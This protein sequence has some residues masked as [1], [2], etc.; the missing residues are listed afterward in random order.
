M[1]P[2]DHAQP[3][4][5][6]GRTPATPPDAPPVRLRGGIGRRIGAGFAV[7]IALMLGVT[8]I[9]LGAGRLVEGRLAR[10]VAHSWPQAVQAEAMRE[11][12]NQTSRSVNRLIFL[13][14]VDD[15]TREKARI[16]AAR[17]ASQAALKSLQASVTEPAG[18]ALLREVDAAL[19]AYAP[20]VDA[21]VALIDDNQTEQ[22]RDLALPQLAPL[23]Q[24]ALDALDQLVALQ[25]REIASEGARAQ[26]AVSDMHRA[27][28][29]VSAAA[30]VLA[31]AI[32][33]FT[34]RSVT[35][36]LADAVAVARRVADGDL[37]S[38]VRAAGDDETGQLL[39]AL[40]AMNGNLRHIVAKVRG[41]T[42]EM[43]GTSREIQ[44]DCAAILTRTENQARAIEAT[45][46]SIEELTSTVA[47]NAGNAH[48]ANDEMGRASA[49][50][51]EVGQVMGQV[52]GT[53][54]AIQE[55]SGRIGEIVGVID[56]IAFQTNILALNAAVEAA[57][58]GEQGR[59]FAV[60]AGE[61]RSLAQ[62]AAT[63]SREIR[64]LIQRSVATV[65]DGN[66]LVDRAST[67]VQGM[68][69]ATGGVAA[70]VGEIAH[71]SRQQHAGIEAFR[72]SIGE[73]DRMAQQN[74]AFVGQVSSAADSLHRNMDALVGAVHVFKE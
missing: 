53:M 40:D 14:T 26:D 62:R 58:A 17:A 64:E 2:V 61:V 15:K 66:R 22:A 30:V 25:G 54:L 65:E 52:V 16:R 74:A 36:P 63:A 20:Q 9:G 7:V 56:G 4:P 67:M 70:L 10:M 49:I 47:L 21:F 34:K 60:V 39:R 35:R 41:G 38:T 23:E 45:A 51:A 42:D 46:A 57:R 55:R 11:Q 68:V 48:R 8:A 69:G 6:P 3:A 72:R 28:L 37:T 50:A 19:R 12:L 29:G 59:G 18:V 27:M 24:R 71:A 33:L 44:A 5:A 43:A 1:P 32:G 31:A 73:L 13:M